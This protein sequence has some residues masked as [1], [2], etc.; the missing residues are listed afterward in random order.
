M[1]THG[2]LHNFSKIMSLSFMF[3]LLK[4]SLRIR[5][6][7]WTAEGGKV[8]FCTR[9]NAFPPPFYPVRLQSLGLYL[10]DISQPVCFEAKLN[11]FFSKIPSSYKCIQIKLKNYICF[12]LVDNSTIMQRNFFEE[13]S[14]LQVIY[15]FIYY[16]PFHL[17]FY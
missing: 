1:K 5:Q 15:L 7:F 9:L 8:L 3:L 17:F 14:V 11:N 6:H 10:N 12:N 16:L 4:M 2:L 13:L